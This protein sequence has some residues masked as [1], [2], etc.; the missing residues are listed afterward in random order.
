MS[1][2]RVIVSDTGPLISLEKL[3]DGYLFIRKLYDSILIPTAVANE[4]FQGEF[5]SWSDY[6]RNYGLTELV[7]RVEV[8]LVSDLPGL[9]L[10]DPGERQAIQLAYAKRLPLLIEDEQGRRV[11]QDLGLQFSGIAGQILKAR[12]LALITDIEAQAKFT[13]LLRA[14]RLGKQL[15]RGLLEAIGGLLEAIE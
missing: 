13:E 15:Y 5:A 9:A 14:G 2:S 10:L 1:L 11:A 8:E 4:L 3:S 7:E 6:E 12:R